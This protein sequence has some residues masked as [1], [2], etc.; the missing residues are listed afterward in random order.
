M[1]QKAHIVCIVCHS[2]IMA[3][4][5]VVIDDIVIS[6]SSRDSFLICQCLN[7]LRVCMTSVEY[8]LHLYQLM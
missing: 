6:G 4:L 2:L 5:A 1:Y 7:E 3:N 8:R